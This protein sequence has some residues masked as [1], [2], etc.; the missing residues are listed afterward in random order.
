M[1]SIF[2]CMTSPYIKIKLVFAFVFPFAFELF[3]HQLKVG[4]DIFCAYF[5]S[6]VC[7]FP[8]TSFF[9]FSYL[10]FLNLVSIAWPLPNSLYFQGLTA[11]MDRRNHLTQAR[12]FTN[13]EAIDTLLKLALFFFNFSVFLQSFLISDFFPSTKPGGIK[14]ECTF[15]SL[16]CA[17]GKSHSKQE[18]EDNSILNHDKFFP[19]KL[20]HLIL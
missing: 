19:R 14:K 13:K 9:F 11:E 10:P 7:N 12:H 20:S 6:L 17:L 4:L 16:L 3:F 1:N 5:F 15:N 18:S 2:L 8:I